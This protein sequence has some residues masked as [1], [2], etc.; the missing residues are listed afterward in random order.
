MILSHLLGVTRFITSESP[1]SA[2]TTQIA[3][4]VISYKFEFSTWPLIRT[5][6]PITPRTSP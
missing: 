1:M 4:S 6:K 5:M 3:I 2:T